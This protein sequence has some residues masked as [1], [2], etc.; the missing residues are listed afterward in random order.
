MK[1]LRGVVAAA[2]LMATLGAGVAAQAGPIAYEGVLNLGETKSH[3]MAHGKGQD[4]KN[5]RNWWSFSAEA[6]D[7][8][9]ITVNR[10]ENSFD[11]AFNLYFGYG[12]DLAELS[13]IDT[14]TGG[15]TKLP[16]YSGRGEDAQYVLKVTSSGMYS[17]EIFNELPNAGGG[18]K[19]FGYQISFGRPEGSGSRP[20]VQS[21]DRSYMPPVPV[22]E[23]ATVG[24]LGAGLLGLGLA[25][26]RRRS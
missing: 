1:I 26:R 14:V 6:G 13:L 19:A 9:V 23:P 16:G 21:P 24:L 10:L 8:V 15:G 3:Q 17:I 20:P 4:K 11:V 2:G 5:A 7:E 18:D 22:D 25:R 12:E